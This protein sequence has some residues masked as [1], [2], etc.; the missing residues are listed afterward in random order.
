M[1][2][3]NCDLM[4]YDY[5]SDILL[6]WKGSKLWLV[7][8]RVF[9][10][11]W[12]RQSVEGYLSLQYIKQH[13]IVMGLA[14]IENCRQKKKKQISNKVNYAKKKGEAKDIYHAKKKVDKKK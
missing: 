4:Y 14:P 3:S 8:R 1:L 5:L 11:Q 10:L 7:E 2:C 9:H 12:S 6:C 13:R